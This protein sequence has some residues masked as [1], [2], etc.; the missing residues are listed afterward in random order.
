VGAYL[1][2]DRSVRNR[3]AE[4][5]ER[6]FRTAFFIWAFL[7]GDRDRAAEMGVHLNA[8]DI[9][10][11]AVAAPLVMGRAEAVQALDGVTPL[12]PVI[13]G[14]VTWLLRHRLRSYGHAE[15][16]TDAATYRHAEPAPS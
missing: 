8:A 11:V 7:N 14:Y 15:Y 3:I 6:S 16:R 2:P 13:D 9:A 10:K 1:R 4:S 12:R 5:F